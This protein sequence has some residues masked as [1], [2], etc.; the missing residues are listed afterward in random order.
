[1]SKIF[2]CGGSSGQLVTLRAV[3]PFAALGPALVG[4]TLEYVGQLFPELNRDSSPITVIEI[5]PDEQEGSW[6]AG[7]YLIEKG[8]IH[9]E[10]CLRTFF[11]AVG[12]T[13]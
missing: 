8:P 7:F 12:G 11:R 4:E 2:Y 3:I 13:T 9:F 6:R 5:M 10:E 1:L